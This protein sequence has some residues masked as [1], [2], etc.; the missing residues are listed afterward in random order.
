MA[1][2]SIRFPVIRASGT[3]Y[4]IGLAHGR[5]GRDKVRTSIE[6]YRGMFS[7]Y[8]G[9]RWDVAKRYAHTFIPAIVRYDP[10]ILEEI[11]GIADG[12]GFELDEILALN[13]RSEI[14][15]QGSQV[16]RCLDGGC[17]SCAFMP[18]KT[19][20]GETWLAQNWDWKAIA[21]GAL[22]VLEIRQN[23]KP[24][25]VMITEAG[26]VGKIGFNSAGV[27]VCLN[28][29]G[30][31]KR[32]EGE[33]VPLHIAL[34]GVLNSY[35]LSDAI[36]RAGNTPL[37]CCANFMMAAASGQCI[38]VEIGPGEIDVIYPDGRGYVTHTN[39]FY[40]PRTAHIR[41]TGRM[42]FPDTYLRQGRIQDLLREKGD[43]K[44]RIADI[45]EILKDHVGWPDSICR[46]E[47]EREA[48]EM[49]CQNNFSIIMNL[50]GREMLY[51]EGA[52]CCHEYRP[53]K[54]ESRDE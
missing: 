15:L 44:I 28:A 47:D 35:T 24:D 51:A 53:Y 3:P 6:C 26:I 54:L 4:E 34:R 11:R 40:G 50:S 36:A 12:S 25:I 17:T 20:T 8:S 21:Q 16:E 7:D 2:S 32:W 23:N 29:L 1:E 31:D 45:Q 49:R 30:S 41:D 33:T 18:G 42:T 9:I 27:G 52:P 43:A 39:H 37:A 5:Q 13:V 22:I 46:H 48:P 14:V 38:S 10:E 19:E